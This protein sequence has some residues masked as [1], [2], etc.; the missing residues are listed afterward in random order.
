[1]PSEWL[2]LISVTETFTFTAKL[3]HR[4]IKK[5]LVRK[6]LR[7]FAAY[8]HGWFSSN[9]SST[10]CSW[11]LTGLSD[12][13]TRLLSDISKRT[14]PVL[15]VSVVSWV[16]FTG[17]FSRWLCRAFSLCIIRSSNIWNVYA[18]MNVYFSRQTLVYWVNHVSPCCVR[19]QVL[20]AK[21]DRW[22]NV[23]D[24]FLGLRCM[25]LWELSL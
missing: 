12:L 9:K 20:A 8:V 11:N 7:L 18:R 16:Y 22:S 15:Y 5:N 1:M 21:N 24:F 19:C 23:V 4:E 13:S 10:H 14:A 3:F 25:S 17:D 2:E 6:L